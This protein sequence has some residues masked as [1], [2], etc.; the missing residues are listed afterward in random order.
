MGGLQ[1]DLKKYEN[2]GT[3]NFFI[4]LSTLFRKDQEL[5]KGFI[6]KYF[7]NR[8]IDGKY[9]FD[10]WYSLL[11][12]IGL[13]N[14]DYDGYLTASDKFMSVE[15]SSVEFSKVILLAFLAKYSKDDVFLEIFSQKN[16]NFDLRSRT[17]R[18]KRCVFSV[19]NINLLDLLLTLNFLS[20][21]VIYGDFLTI[22][23]DFNRD[24]TELSGKSISSAQSIEDLLKIQE[25]QREL[26][27]LSERFVL[28]FEKERVSSDNLVLWISPI[29]TTKGFDI[30]SYE[31]HQCNIDRYIEVKSYSNEVSVHFF[32]SKNEIKVAK[33]NQDKYFLYLVDRSRINSQSYTPRIIKNPYKFFFVDSNNW[34]KTCSNWFFRE[35]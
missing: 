13:I 22:N 15:N 26:G 34:S 21:D 32:W 4:E 29:D 16:L 8:I 12:N 20:E 7:F 28:E 3:L 31:N 25:K 19:K 30:L 17:L 10:G 11:T 2:L 23:R 24:F 18:I 5:R 14:V 6:D 27:E 9:I 1:K 33:E 35:G